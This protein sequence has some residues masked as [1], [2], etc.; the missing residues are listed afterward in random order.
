M[1]TIRPDRVVRTGVVV[2]T[3]N[4]YSPDANA[5][6][7]AQKFASSDQLR[8]AGSMWSRFKTW[9]RTSYAQRQAAA[10]YAA[11]AATPPNAIVTDTGVPNAPGNTLPPS[12]ASP[13]YP[14][15]SPDATQMAAMG[16]YITSGFHPGFVPGVV[17]GKQEAA[18][19]LFG[20]NGITQE[21]M[22]LAVMASA[23]VNGG[24]RAVEAGITA[25]QHRFYAMNK[26]RITR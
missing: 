12:T 24:G 3:G 17:R 15:Q 6:A 9:M 2:P 4:G 5:Y 22:R 18:H 26:S 7:V 11:A 21:P 20:N 10:V 13:S 19:D 8:G 14:G 23:A 16:T 1:L 25:A